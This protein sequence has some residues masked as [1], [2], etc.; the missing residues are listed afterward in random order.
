[1]AL[2][3]AGTVLSTEWHW[4]DARY[5]KADALAQTEEKLTVTNET[6]KELKWEVDALYLKVIPSADRFPLMHHE[7]HTH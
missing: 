5:A 6:A 1:M 7:N 4:I 3:F 2:G